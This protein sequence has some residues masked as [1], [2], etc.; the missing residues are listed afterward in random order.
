MIQLPSQNLSI[1]V[2]HRLNKYQQEVDQEPSYPACVDA[3]KKLFSKRNKTSNKTFLQI[4]ETLTIMCSGARRCCYCE[5]SVADE[6]EHIRPKDLYPERVFVWENYVYA[7]GPCNGPKNNKFA[8]I[9]AATGNLVEVNRPKNMPVLPPQPGQPAL[10]DPRSEDP[11]EYLELDLLGTFYFVPK[12]NLA[13]IKLLRA[14]YTLDVL[15]LNDRDYLVDARKESYGSYR[16]RLVEY[17]YC[18]NIGA[19]QNQ[20]NILLSSIQH[21]QHPTVWREM[22]R[23]YALIPELNHLFT[24]V[25]EALNW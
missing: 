16:A 4:R 17:I 9:D 15:H 19:S 1:A 2:Q 12:N 14:N 3:A 13:A 5:D 6:I 10:I 7:C 20:L 18:K 8:V 11:L 24:Q 22:Q 21:L 23:Q 25:P